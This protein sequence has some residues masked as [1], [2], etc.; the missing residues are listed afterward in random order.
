M[1]CAGTVL[2]SGEHEHAGGSAA[3]ETHPAHAAAERGGETQGELFVGYSV[4]VRAGGKD[5]LTAVKTL[6]EE[7]DGALRACFYLLFCHI[8][9]KVNYGCIS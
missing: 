8:V 9:C 7:F 6:F 4:Q 2:K 5:R 1:G 3:D